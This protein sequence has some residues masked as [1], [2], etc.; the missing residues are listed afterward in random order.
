MLL[1]FGF[2]TLERVSQPL[3]SVQKKEKKNVH[4]KKRK[5]CAKERMKKKKKMCKRKKEKKDSL[6]E[7]E[8][9]LLLTKYPLIPSGLTFLSCA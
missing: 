2:H 8:P 7:G 3:M 5:K 1:W 6:I 4:K 9:P